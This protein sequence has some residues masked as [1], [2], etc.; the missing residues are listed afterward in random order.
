MATWSIDGEVVR[1]LNS[2]FVD[3]WPNE[4]M[5]LVLNNA[6]RTESPNL[7]TTYPNYLIID[8]I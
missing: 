8:Y 2:T 4:D 5:Y 3:Q 7:T 6:V 1:I